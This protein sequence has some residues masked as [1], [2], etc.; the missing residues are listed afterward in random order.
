MPSWR[1]GHRWSSRT[2]RV[3]ARAV[4]PFSLSVS[5]AV[6]ARVEPAKAV[7]LASEW[8]QLL[9]IVARIGI[10][11]VS[12]F[13][14][15][16]TYDIVRLT[17]GEGEGAGICARSATERSACSASTARE[18]EQFSTSVAVRSRGADQ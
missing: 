18:E 15:N 2:R 14:N 7:A 12:A 3:R 11:A 8:A 16:M 10:G 1:R 17:V 4:L 6:V 5:Y 9:G 13:I